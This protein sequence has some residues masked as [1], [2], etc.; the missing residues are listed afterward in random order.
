MNDTRT[1]TDRISASMLRLRSRSPFF[2]T[3]ALAARFTERADIPTAATDGLDVFYNAEFVES[4]TPPHLDGVLLH[5][6]LH[7]ALDHVGR[8]TARDAHLWNVAADVVVNGILIANDFDL[9]D[10]H[11]RMAKLE[12]LSVEEVFTVLRRDAEGKQAQGE[13]EAGPELAAEDH[14]LLTPELSRKG[15]GQQR[16]W[17]AAIDRAAAVSRGAKHGQLPAGIE[18]AFGLA[19]R[20]RLDWRAL[21]WRFVTRTPT[22]F[23]AFDRRLI[24]RGLYLETLEATSVRVVA[25][26]DTSG[27]I[28]EADL[29]AFTSELLGVLSAYPGVKALLAYADAEVYGPWHIEPGDELPP[30]QG[31]GGTDFCPLFEAMEQWDAVDETTVVVY[32]TDGYGSFPDEPPAWPVLW[33][34]TPGGLADDDFPFGE[35]ARLEEE[36]RYGA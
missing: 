8:R 13:G 21:L 30:V 6:V 16:R 10:G 31:G 28:N 18:R 36:S 20:P 29:A 12:G 19:D 7:A 5:E 17:A 33:V 23:A 34:V 3:L 27:S 14:D 1:V 32:L 9:P 26:I 15:E 2:A 35:V 24:H 11:V 25:C 22:D 4:L